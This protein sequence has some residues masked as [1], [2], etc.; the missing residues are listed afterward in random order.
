MQSC[1]NLCYRKLAT[2][3]RKKHYKTKCTRIV[4]SGVLKL[5]GRRWCEKKTFMNFFSQWTHCHINEWMLCEYINT[6]LEIL[7]SSHHDDDR[8]KLK[9]K[10]NYKPL[11]TF[12]IVLKSKETFW[13][14][15]IQ[16]RN[17]FRFKNIATCEVR[18]T[19][20]V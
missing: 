19:I 17:C 7:K 15:I 18:S 1:F 3:R 14:S 11:T 9:T 10:D 5:F 6:I 12:V 4:G 8:L 16:W 13:F 2:D 20:F